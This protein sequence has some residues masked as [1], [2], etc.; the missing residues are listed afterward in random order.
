MKR[1][2]HLYI[3]D[4]RV[5]LDDDALILFTYSQED[6]EHPTIVK[7]SY[8]QGITLQP[9]RRNNRIFGEVFRLDRRTIIGDAYTG[10]FFDPTR[11][12]P[13]TIYDDA[14]RILESGYCKL[15]QITEDGGYNVTLF[16]GL[17]SFLYGLTY[18]SEG[19]KL[20]LASLD[21]LAT[22]NTATEL[23]YTIDQNTLNTAW[24]S[25]G[26]GK[27]GVINFAP[28]YNG[29]PE[30]FS[31]DKV[32]IDVNNS[33]IGIPASVIND[34]KTYTAHNGCV[35]A[36]VNE[37]LNEWMTRDLR[38]YLQRPVISIKALI[39]AICEERN[40][41]GY[42]VVL[43]EA[44]FNGANPYY[45]NAWMTLPLLPSQ[46]YLLNIAVNNYEGILKAYTPTKREAWYSD[47]VVTTQLVGM[48][49]SGQIKVGK[50]RITTAQAS[51]VDFTFSRGAYDI[52]IAEGR[53]GAGNIVGCSNA[54][55]LHESQTPASGLQNEVAGFLARNGYNNVPLTFVAGTFQK[56][57]A[58]AGNTRFE[59]SGDEEQMLNITNMEGAMTINLRYYCSQNYASTT[60][61][62]Y[63]G[64]DWKA[65]GFT[66]TRNTIQSG[67]V[68]S[69]ET[70]L[71]GTQTPADY[72]LSYCRMFG[73]NITCDAKEKI[74][75]ILS[76]NTFYGN[77]YLVDI[78]DRIVRSPK[79]AI[80][81]NTYAHRWLTFTQ[82]SKGGAKSDYYRSLYGIDY[83][84]KRVNT[85]Y[86]FNAD[87]KQVFDKLVFNGGVQVLEQG[88]NYCDVYKG[89][90]LRK[91]WQRSAHTLRYGEGD[92]TFEQEVA[93]FAP[94]SYKYYNDGV[95]FADSVDRPQFCDA[96]GKAID[97]SGV[98]LFFNGMVSTPVTYYLTDDTSEML[99][100]NDNVPCWLVS[101]VQGIPV[102]ELPS[103]SRFYGSSQLLKT[104]D[105]ELAKE[106]FVPTFSSS[107]PNCGIY[108]QFWRNYIEDRC[109]VDTSIV[110]AK[111]NLRGL[112]IGQD[113]LR[114]FYWFDNSA[115][116]LN[117]VTDYSLTTAGDTECEFIRVQNIVAY[118]Q[119]AGVSDA[120]YLS[121]S[122]ASLSASIPAE[123]GVAVF[124]VN[125]STAWT[126]TA[127]GGDMQVSV[128]RTSGDVG[129][130][131]VEITCNTPNTG[132]VKRASFRIK[133]ENAE[134]VISV[135]QQADERPDTRTIAFKSQSASVAK[136]AGSFTTDIQTSGDVEPEDILVQ[137]SASWL[138]VSG[139]TK[140]DAS[141]LRVTYAVTANSN[142][143]RTGKLTA[144]IK[145][146][147]DYVTFS[148]TQAQGEVT[149]FSYSPQG[150]IVIS[151]VAHTEYIQ[152][153][154]TQAWTIVLDSG[155]SYGIQLDTSGGGAG[156]H[157]IAMQVTA[158][159]SST[160][161]SFTIKIKHGT[162]TRY[163]E[164]YQKSATTSSYLTP[165]GA[166][167]FVFGADSGDSKSAS[168]KASGSWKVDTKPAWLD[169][170]PAS[171]TSGTNKSITMTTNSV[172][173]GKTDYVELYL[174]GD[175][176][177]TLRLKVRQ[178]GAYIDTDISTI[179]IPKSGTSQNVQVSASGAWQV[180]TPTASW[181][182][183]TKDG[184]NLVISASPYTGT[185]T[186]SV[187][188]SL[189]DLPA[190]KKTLTIV[191]EGQSDVVPSIATGIETMTFAGAGE[192]IENTIYA[193]SAWE[194]ASKPEWITITHS[195]QAGSTTGEAM[196]LSAS[197]NETGAVRS[198]Q[199]VVRL[200]SDTSISA[201]IA[202]SQKAMDDFSVT[203]SYSVVGAGETSLRLEVASN[204]KW[205]VSNYP[206]M[207]SAIT[208]TQG[209]GNKV[210][211][212][213]ISVNTGNATRTGA[214]TFV[215][216]ENYEKTAEVTIA[217]EVA[218]ISV[219]TSSLS[220]SAEGGTM[221]IELTTSG[222]WEVVSKPSWINV[223]PLGYAGA[224]T[225]EVD[226]IAVPNRFVQTLE[227]NVVFGIVGTNVRA[228]IKVTQAKAGV[229]LE[230]EDEYN[231]V[232]CEVTN[233][234]LNI[235]CNTSW[236]IVE[237]SAGMSF[238]L[239]RGYG[240]ATNS[241][242]I[243]AN[244]TR[245]EKTYT[246]KVRTTA[247]GS[248][249]M[250]KIITIKQENALAT[251][252]IS[253]D[254]LHFNL[255]NL[256][257]TF[258]IRSTKSWSISADV[259][260][261]SFEP[262]EG[263][264]N[265][266][267]TIVATAVV[268]YTLTDLQ[269]GWANVVSALSEKSF[270]VERIAQEPDP[271]PTPDGEVD[272]PSTTITRLSVSDKVLEFTP[273]KKQKTIRVASPTSWSLVCD[274]DWLTITP[275]YGDANA[276]VE[277]QVTADVPYNAN[278]AEAKGYIYTQGAQVELT[279]IR[280][281]LGMDDD[282][283]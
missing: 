217:Q 282:I 240:D 171:G 122:P 228:S 268:P 110:T 66:F 5:D 15:D 82:E 273:S 13:F 238:N 212:A 196:S 73:L 155:T 19:E 205:K 248:Q 94:T 191:Q 27:W 29:T 253:T 133:N 256:Q 109:H 272:T 224:G 245:Y 161:R 97:G 168:F 65:E 262:H 108:S 11:K 41:G 158:N 165:N 265:Q 102:T 180:G 34:G 186:A 194:V 6:L 50:L 169:I 181:V 199:V 162:T 244:I 3:A 56:V 84:I 159:N 176:D 130:T 16:G 138:S 231:E 143:E 202:V 170:T 201:T 156:R 235:I 187:E 106:L 75:T 40:N 76:R 125:S 98:L 121:I 254:L 139:V 21:Y 210:I 257:R 149:S 251:I 185:R 216:G 70:M 148:V 77:E 276:V 45:F 112:N 107:S 147:T 69:K 81:P 232:E 179:T 134:R 250:E 274:A 124:A 174:T 115:W 141:T 105:F 85:G 270:I 163:I 281:P 119:G 99:F 153:N 20:S 100:Q 249:N 204:V 264:R 267:Y 211:Y 151:G 88:V 258:T 146:K 126:L 247:T 113:S 142:P 95:N 263:F 277:V 233:I 221:S 213:T 283:N 71:A 53:D 91:F 78:N 79:P 203:P 49:A 195:T 48:T 207:V 197:K 42:R 209:T 37:S 111:V 160:E 18:N 116:I 275:V 129:V 237:A 167:E 26:Q 64:I 198:G 101:N 261:I 137:G 278:Y 140:V 118:S 47:S 246:A 38:S 127:E 120:S 31:T 260:W 123:G 28:A 60:Y 184:N 215:Y 58:S 104:W 144:N 39:D 17:G 25:I 52:I 152:V 55:V 72:L 10:A 157:Q 23:T 22:G 44:F 12:T 32:L 189:V 229:E 223:V 36:N 182:T 192:T 2:I 89:T 220:Y 218:T 206:A 83:G 57:S 178:E 225:F 200:T 90:D 61:P 188:I 266:T 226:V 175:P 242:T 219:D 173:T 68:I 227:G 236:E 255:N 136:G 166:T 35:L 183:A 54:I 269:L 128:N 1:N 252:E 259:P 222:T 8:S 51:N 154:A 59:W 30:N 145:G 43:D 241:I 190:I 117:K 114:R 214:I 87:E 86:E 80:T 4:Q 135:I 63:M 9:T 67:A 74:V 7:N 132:S 230:V 92:N 96:E 131:R 243:P 24:N 279:F 164:Y 103:F 271:D 14:G 208:E 33:G 177:V 239:S 193:T 150:G 234:P 62:A 172:A 280:Q 93:P 46:K